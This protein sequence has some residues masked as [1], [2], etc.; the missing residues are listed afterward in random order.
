VSAGSRIAL[1]V[2][3]VAA[4]GPAGF[5]TYRLLAAAHWIAPGA[6]QLTA[7]RSSSAGPT[8]TASA[9]S[10][11]S[12]ASAL[13]RP[14]QDQLPDLSFPDQD[15]TMRRLSS[16]RGQPL[17]VN[18]W[19]TWCEPCRREIP[20]FESLRHG[21]A[22]RGLQVVG[23]A[24]DER[25]AALKYARAMGIDYPILIAGEDAGLKAIGAFGAP[26]VLPFTVIADDQGRIVD[27]K[28][29]ELHPDE[30]HLILARLLD[31]DAGRLTL[32][33]AREQ[34]SSG[35]KTLALERATHSAGA[36]G[37]AADH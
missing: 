19:A 28:V 5:L 30:A 7:S 21:P 1:A 4:A 31:L 2:L 14:T 16:W 29:G 37:S 15:G 22:A 6:P 27:V 35:L 18:F 32:A 8:V 10:D 24:V 11:E 23:I 9:A 26:G 12:A 36:A 33:A 20:L 34:I 13:G 17:I 25:G 3:L